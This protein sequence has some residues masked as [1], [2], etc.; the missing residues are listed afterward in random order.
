MSA[1]EFGSQLEEVMAMQAYDVEKDSV[2]TIKKAVDFG[3]LMFNAADAAAFDS[4]NLEG[5]SL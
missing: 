3:S 4:N 1:S 2:F 5:M